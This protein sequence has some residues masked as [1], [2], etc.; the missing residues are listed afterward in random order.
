M[1][2]IKTQYIHIENQSLLTS[3]ILAADTPDCRTVITI[4]GTS[5]R[6]ELLPVPIPREFNRRA[7]W[8]YRNLVR[9]SKKYVSNYRRKKA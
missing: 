4:E 1:S 3:A 7:R 8:G 9:L 6:A 5:F 2:G